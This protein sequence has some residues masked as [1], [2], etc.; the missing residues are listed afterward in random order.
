MKTQTMANKTVL[1]SGATAGIGF[2]TAR[3]LA[4]MAAKVVFIAR[5]RGRAE[6]ARERIKEETG[7]G[8]VEFLIADL[9]FQAQVRSAAEQFLSRFDGLDVLV[10]N[11]GAL[12]WR[13]TE[14]A[15]G[16]EATFALNHL[17]PFLLTNL[18]LGALR[19]KASARVV[20]VSSHAHVGA[21]MDF[22]DLEGRR[23]YKGFRAYGQS[24]LA[25]LLFTYALA[26]KL[27]GS[28]MTANALHPG[29]VASQFAKNNGGFVRGLM[30]LVQRLG[31]A[32][33]MEEGAK[34]S[35][36][37]ASS[38]EVAKVTGKYFVKC[39]ETPSSAASR[40]AQ[41]MQ[42]LWEISSRMTALKD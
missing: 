15:D 25:N 11:V 6:A 7:N 34:T 10:N 8:S 27:E 14:T 42:R 12:F 38:P 9:S 5:D 24:K 1:I 18:L 35:I 22:E 41:S 39:R 13:R 29:F 33:S 32:I 31:G 36:F 3:E 26:K 40:D 37:L 17:A 4:D 16:F 30:P 20:T 19:R 28:G 2:V 21:T 23:S